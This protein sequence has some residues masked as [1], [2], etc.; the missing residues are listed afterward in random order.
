MS[1]KT[2]SAGE[3]VPARV[4]QLLI[5]LQ[6]GLILSLGSHRTSRKSEVANHLPRERAIDC[7]SLIPFRSLFF[8]LWMLVAFI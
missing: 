4:L 6:N 5:L 8:F 3:Q 7:S 1:L 2:A